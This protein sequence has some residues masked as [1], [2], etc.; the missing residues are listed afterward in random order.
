MGQ[1]ILTV[2][3]AEAN[4]MTF[5]ASCMCAEQLLCVNH[6]ARLRVTEMAKTNAVFH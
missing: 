1:A 4:S 6:P 2:A 3:G 5:G